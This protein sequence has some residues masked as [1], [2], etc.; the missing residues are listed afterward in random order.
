[1]S[2][3]PPPLLR[4]PRKRGFFL[5]T[6]YA[7]DDCATLSQC[8]PLSWACQRHTR[9]MMKISGWERRRS[10][11]TQSAITA[12]GKGTITRK[13]QSGFLCSMARE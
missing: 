1:M 6:V 9:P 13:S 2:H 8:L 4:K 5:P 12:K 10:N 7:W 11:V 3:I